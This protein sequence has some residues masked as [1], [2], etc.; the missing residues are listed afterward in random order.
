MAAGARWAPDA[1]AVAEKAKVLLTCVPGSPEL[2]ELM[3]GSPD[4]PGLLSRLRPGQIWVD[5]TSASPELARRLAA[6][7]QHIGVGYL[8]A[9]MGGGP[10][11]ADQGGLTLFVGG[12]ALLLD[13]VRPVLQCLADPAAIWHMGGAG[14]GYLS[15][16]LV[17]LLWF[18]QAASVAETLLLAQ[19]SGITPN[20]MAEVLSRS[21]A[22]SEFITTYLPRLLDGEYLTTFGLDRCAE[23]LTSLQQLAQ[24]SKMPFNVS[25]AVTGLH[26][27]ALDRF[28]PIDGELA[29][30]AL[31]EEHAGKL[32]RRASAPPAE[33]Q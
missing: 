4:Q 10:A 8:D 20:R 27:Q 32:L 16:L 9:G 31:L 15:K 18:S 17:N 12:P 23:E 24:E 14:T 11:E 33:P 25:A 28:G 29:A 2:Q 19:Q 13:Q 21:A 7:A 5:L 30:I 26:Q 22:G 3:F 1:A 6:A